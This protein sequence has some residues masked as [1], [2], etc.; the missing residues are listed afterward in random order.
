MLTRVMVLTACGGLLLCAG[1]SDDN[2]GSTKDAI[3]L[4]DQN[5]TQKDTGVPD[6]PPLPDLSD[7]GSSD[8][9]FEWQNA[10]NPQQK[11]STGAVS[12]TDLAGGVKETQVDAT[13]GGVSEAIKN[14]YVY[15]SLKDGS[16]VAIDDFAARKDST[17]DLAL[18]RTIIRVNGGDSGPGKGAVA[19]LAGKTLDQV[20]AI[21]ASSS[22][23]TDDFIDDNCVIQY[24]DAQYIK[25]A[26]GGQSGR[27]YDF[28]TTNMKV[29]VRPDTYVIRTASGDH[30]KLVIKAYYDT[31]GEG[32]HFTLDWS[33]LK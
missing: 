31:A 3:Q 13:A 25:T 27:W 4:S 12:T 18:R 15:I 14:P 16:K 28:D 33:P 19:V 22:F 2:G 23:L 10:V 29:Q 5:V 1:C 32:G 9:D 20:T 7:L 8:C 21:P 6:L 11:V 26:F 17:W 24:N 30:V